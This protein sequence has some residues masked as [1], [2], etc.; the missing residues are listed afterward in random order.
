MM[1]VLPVV[2]RVKPEFR[3]G[4]MQGASYHSQVTGVLLPSPTISIRH[5][6]RHAV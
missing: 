2:D 1:E 5:I 4:V 6:C 3:S